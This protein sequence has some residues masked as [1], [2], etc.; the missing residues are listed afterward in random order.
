MANPTDPLVLPTDDLATF[1]SKTATIMQ[2]KHDRPGQTIT[3]QELARYI[4]AEWGNGVDDIL[5]ALWQR[6]GGGGA[7]VD[8]TPLTNR[9]TA[10]ETSQGAQDLS[11]TSLNNGLQT[12]APTVSPAL[13]GTPV[14]PTAAAGT[15]TTQI[16]TCAYV[17]TAIA[18]LS[19]GGGSSNGA[20]IDSPTFTGTPRA[21]T[22]SN[23]DNSTRIATTEYVKLQKYAPITNPFFLD[24]PKTVHPAAGSNNNNIASTRW[25]NTA[26]SLASARTTTNLN[27]TV[28]QA[29]RA[30]AIAPMNAWSPIVCSGPQVTPVTSCWSDGEYSCGFSDNVFESFSSGGS[31]TA[32]GDSSIKITGRLLGRSLRI[33]NNDIGC[34]TMRHSGSNVLFQMFLASSVTVSYIRSL[35]SSAKPYCRMS[36]STKVRSGVETVYFLTR[37]SPSTNEYWVTAARPNIAGGLSVALT[38]TKHTFPGGNDIWIDGHS[39]EVLVGR[40]SRVWRSADKGA[41][42]APVTLEGGGSINGI[43]H[44]VSVHYSYSPAGNAWRYAFSVQ[45]P[46]NGQTAVYYSTSGSSFKKHTIGVGYGHHKVTIVNGPLHAVTQSDW[47]ELVYL[48]STG[49]PYS[50]G[51]VTPPGLISKNGDYLTAVPSFDWKYKRLA[52]MGVNT[53]F[54]SSAALSDAFI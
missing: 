34:I 14:A 28:V 16:A 18:G 26:I 40:G 3:G 7:A 21:P 22:P 42:F 9:V 33:T 15:N 27:N 8:L 19:S 11:I 50:L 35:S 20:P 30:A 44:D 54:I 48:P 13:T 2:K 43:V 53:C 4:G 24:T 23:L 45:E 17:Q 31:P 41:T 52:I 1:Q 38:H 47:I 37:D 25:T 5:R 39:D 12:K 36:K 49:T 29:R 10:L 51:K 46:S 6:G 32:Y